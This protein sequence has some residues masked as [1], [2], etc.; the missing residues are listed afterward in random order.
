MSWRYFT[1]LLGGLGP[2]SAIVATQS[3]RTQG[4]RTAS[5]EQVIEIDMN[6]DPELV[7][8]LFAGMVAKTPKRKQKRTP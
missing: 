4:S 1:V 6:K 3:S 8:R 7:D 5:G 2:N